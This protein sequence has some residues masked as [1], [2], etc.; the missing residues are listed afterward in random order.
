MAHPDEDAPNDATTPDRRNFIQ[1]IIDRDLE[2]GKNEGQIVTRFPPEP[3]GYLHIGHAKAICVNFGMAEEFGGRCHLR[4]DDTNPSKEDTEY[5]DAIQEDIRWLGFDWGEHLHFASDYFEKLYE[6]AVE[7]IEAGHAYVCDLTPDETR[8]YRGTITSPGKNSP[9]RDRTPAENLDLFQRM[10]AGEFEDGTR[11]LRAKIDMASP[12]L[13]MRDPVMVRISRAHHHRTGD[14]WCI[15]PM[16]DWAHGQSDAIEGITHSLCT[17]EFE[18]HRPLYEWFLERI[19]APSHPQQIEYARLAL[20]YTMTSKRKLLRLVEDGHVTGWDDPRMPTLRGLRRRGYT[21][22]SIRNFC[23]G[24]GLAKFNSTVDM[25]VLENSIRED[26]N[27]RAPRAMGVLDPLKLVIENYPED[28]EEW[29]EAVNNPEDPEAG[30][31]EVP[32]SRVLFIERE[33]FRE[34]APRKYFRLKPGQEVRLRYAY[35]V[36]CTGFEKDPETGAITEVRCTYDP[37]TR[38]GDSP[39]GRKVKGTIHWVSARHAARAEIRVFDHLFRTPDPNEGDDF[40]ANLNPESLVVLHDRP[41]EPSLS[42]AQPG[43][44]L[45]LERQGYFCVDAV[46]SKPDKLVLNRTVALRDSWARQ[47][48]RAQKAPGA[49]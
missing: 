1:A 23:T 7:L 49:R 17:L 22:E 38:G 37:E 14:A 35:Y 28:G 46:D 47:E 8:E 33:D 36:T 48:K 15:Y 30:T 32:F 39:D 45:Q 34:E 24:V 18:N 10:R 12:N 5:V 31:R 9:Y 20:T 44:S 3:N 26:L 41:V 43:D 27:R 21:P 4:F 40:T 16:Y 6:F 29:L 11:T 19:T 2:A 42:S 13:N 25:V